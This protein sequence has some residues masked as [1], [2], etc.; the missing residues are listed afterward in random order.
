MDLLLLWQRSV[1][2]YLR[3]RASRLTRTELGA[4]LVEY[5]LL[6]ALIAAV[7]IIAVQFLGSATS[8]KY[9]EIGSSLP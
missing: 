8:A 6:L 4:G 9:N 1:V 7:C 3:A 2:P 5:A